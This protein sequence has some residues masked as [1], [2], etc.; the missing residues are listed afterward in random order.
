MLNRALRMIVRDPE[1][2]FSMA[3]LLAFIGLATLQ[4]GTRYLLGQQFI[5]TEELSSMLIIW[6]TFIGA[7][8]VERRC[9]HIRVELAEDI[10]PPRVVRWLYGFFDLI[11]IFTLI[12]IVI[13]GW[14]NMLEMAF[15]RSPALRIPWRYILLVV[16]AAATLMILYT[17]RNFWRR[18]HGR[19]IYPDVG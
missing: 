17:L 15:L 8:G 9:G 6:L 5:W 19:P 4:V 14:K 16:P 3:I 18:M 12:C 1:L 2:S 11:I 10:F 7:A 13:A